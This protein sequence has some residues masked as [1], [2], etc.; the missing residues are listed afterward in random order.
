[1]QRP[2][3]LIVFPLCWQACL[4]GSR[5]PFDVKTERFSSGDLRIMRRKHADKAK[6]YIVSPVKLDDL[7]QPS[8]ASDKAS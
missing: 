3:T 1:M 5:V 2:E 4:L 8:Q 6:R 7:I